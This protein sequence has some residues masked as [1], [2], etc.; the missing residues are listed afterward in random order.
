MNTTERVALRLCDGWTIVKRSENEWE[1]HPPTAG[2]PEYTGPPPVGY[3][4]YYTGPPI[5][6]EDDERAV[7]LG[8]DYP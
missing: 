6:V 1:W 4:Y 3:T 5:P 7:L 8:V 2:V